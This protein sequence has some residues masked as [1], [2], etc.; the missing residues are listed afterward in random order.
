MI[1]AETTSSAENSPEFEKE[2]LNA[3]EN[4]VAR[5]FTKR[6]MIEHYADAILYH[7]PDAAHLSKSTIIAKTTALINHIFDAILKV[8]P[9]NLSKELLRLGR[10]QPNRISEWFAEFDESY[11]HYKSSSKLP[12]IAE[13]LMPSMKGTQSLLDFG[14][15]DGEIVTFLA[16]ELGLPTVSGVDVLDWRSQKNKENSAFAFYQHNFSDR[17]TEAN[18]PPHSTG[19]MHAMLHHVSNKPDEISSYLQAASKAIS[20]RLLVVED[21]LYDKNLDYTALPGSESLMVAKNSQPNFGEYLNLELQDQKDV[22]T[23]LDLLSNS[24]AMGIPEM[25]FPF[26]AQELNQWVKIFE[27]SGLKLKNI[28]VLGFQDHLFHRMSQVLFELET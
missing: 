24:L 26:G 28:K 23:M 12:F 2:F 16:K 15:G 5:E 4:D 17:N 3:V 10:K 19:L 20:G 13:F 14:C 11:D 27:K 21:V 9:E 7:H 1:D 8:G 6:T 18:I 22:I 25:N